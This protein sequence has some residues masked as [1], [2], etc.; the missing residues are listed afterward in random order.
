[1]PPG[2][3]KNR[4]TES[5]NGVS[6]PRPLAFTEGDLHVARCLAA[7]QSQAA[8]AFTSPSAFSLTAP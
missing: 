8:L 5:L 4:L 3:P 2:H 6:T 7:T 1:M